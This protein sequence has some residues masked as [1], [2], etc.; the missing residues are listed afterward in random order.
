M[1]AAEVRE[2]ALLFRLRAHITRKLCV[3]FQTQPSTAIGAARKA[4]PAS[5]F[6]AGDHDISPSDVLQRTV[7]GFNGE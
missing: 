3:V 2:T 1:V 4:P 6:G 7:G 5:M